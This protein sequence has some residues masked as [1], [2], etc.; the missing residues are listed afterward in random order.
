MIIN[1][2]EVFDE[3]LKLNILPYHI[4]CP[5]L[6][7]RYTYLGNKST[8][9]NYS[10]RD[11]TPSEFA[12]KLH[13]MIK[14]YEKGNMNEEEQHLFI[15]LYQ[16][17]LHHVY[18]ELDPAMQKVYLKRFDSEQLEEI[19]DQIKMYQLAQSMLLEQHNY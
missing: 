10:E 5:G 13:E 12:D 4:S 15:K 19:M 8:I 7:A 11:A 2:A 1:D 3:L 6:S 18:A 9:T 16:Y 14:I 17:L